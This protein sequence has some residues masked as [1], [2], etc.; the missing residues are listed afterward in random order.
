MLLFTVLITVKASYDILNLS[1]ASR[2]RT[3]RHAIYPDL[4]A[5]L[6]FAILCLFGEGASELFCLKRNLSSNFGMR[7]CWKFYSCTISCCVHWRV[8]KDNSKDR[9]GAG[10]LAWSRRELD[11]S[12]LRW[13]FL[14]G[15]GVSFH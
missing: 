3:F 15:H 2:C 10:L 9:P 6:R 1:F 12:K 8:L 11:P 13:I 4:L 14:T 5:S 7:C